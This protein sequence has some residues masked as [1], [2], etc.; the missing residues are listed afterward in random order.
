MIRKELS[1]GNVAVRL[2][3][4]CLAWIAGCQDMG[5]NGPATTASPASPPA[6]VRQ[7]RI[8]QKGPVQPRRVSFDPRNSDRLLVMQSNGLTS[9][10]QVADRA[11]PTK[12]LEV[13]SP[14]VDAEFSADGKSIFTAGR[15]GSVR[16]W[17]AEGK[18]IW[19]AEISPKTVV[20]TIGVSPDGTVVAAG[21]DDGKIHILTVD[22][23]EL[24]SVDTG[25][26]MVL[27]LNFS[28]KGDRLAC[29]GS[30][31][32]VRIFR[33]IEPAPG[34]ELEGTFR[35]PNERYAK[36]LPNLIRLD[37][38]WGWQES[39]VF[40]PD[41]TEVLAAN[42]DG[43][44]QFWTVDGKPRR[45]PFSNHGHHHIRAVAFS[46]QGNLVASGGFDG[47]AQLWTTNQTPAGHPLTA[48]NNVITSIAFSPDG[49]TIATAGMDD[50]V[51]LWDTTGGRLGMLP[52]GRAPV[53]PRSKAK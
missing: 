33:R 43:T 52:R 2:G 40:S 9:L 41:G 53:L 29:D 51:R 36:M 27:S 16:R 14:A 22:G 50:S 12:V 15:D 4:V 30:D 38:Q 37:V 24:G 46:P 20:R 28:A 8:E 5:C 11:Q 21:G 1:K 44:C 42:L 45:R 26:E 31:T 23:V 18:E 39:I 17:N 13:A 47:K 32:R 10:W 7:T 48:H 19:R 35:E 6:P 3:L 49:K 25:Q 34:I